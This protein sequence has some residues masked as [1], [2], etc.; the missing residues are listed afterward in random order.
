MKNI[1][2]H[3]VSVEILNSVINNIE[4]IPEEDFQE[5]LSIIKSILQHLDNEEVE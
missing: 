2:I 4:I 1:D 5:R 3:R